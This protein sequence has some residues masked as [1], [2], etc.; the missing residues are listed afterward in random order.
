MLKTDFTVTHTHIR[1]NDRHSEM[2]QR[3]QILPGLVPSHPIRA[4]R[5]PGDALQVI[6]EAF[7]G[8]YGTKL[9]P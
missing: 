8:R 3:P 5:L 7:N 4:M 2:P 9:L 6:Q 1:S